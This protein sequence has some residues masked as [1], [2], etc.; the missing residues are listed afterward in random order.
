VTGRGIG[1]WHGNSRF[2]L[3]TG[4]PSRAGPVASVRADTGFLILAAVDRA[5]P[6][7]WVGLRFRASGVHLRRSPLTVVDRHIGHAT[8]TL[9]LAATPTLPG[10]I[11]S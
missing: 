5:M 6:R 8:G 4:R 9:D 10:A 11:S 3:A 1:Y 7:T 2:D